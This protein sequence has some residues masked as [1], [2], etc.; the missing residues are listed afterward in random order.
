MLQTNYA[1][2]DLGIT[3]G[4]AGAILEAIGSH[5]L[6]GFVR[7]EQ[8]R[9]WY[10][11]LTERGESVSVTTAAIGDPRTLFA[12]GPRDVTG[13][14]IFV[15]GELPGILLHTTDRAAVQEIHALVVAAVRANP[16]E[17]GRGAA[18]S[19]AK[20]RGIT[21]SPCGLGPSLSRATPQ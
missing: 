15:N 10:D 4:E 7:T 21:A 2:P 17:G 6:R 16:A 19:A 9:A 1:A 12:H 8:G 13:Y 18:L 5:D 11:C 20:A 14:R 3:E